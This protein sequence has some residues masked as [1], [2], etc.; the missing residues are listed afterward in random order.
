MSRT[1]KRVRQVYAELRAALGEHM[2]AGEILGLAAQ[3]VE[4]AEKRTLVDLTRAVERPEFFA[5]DEMI[6]Q[7]G[8]MLVEDARRDGFFEDDDWGYVRPQGDFH[9]M[10]RMAA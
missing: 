2:S 9:D 3:I 10:M 5:V 1:A 8:W 6:G 4:L 7:R